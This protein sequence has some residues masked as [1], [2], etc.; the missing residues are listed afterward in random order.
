[1]PKRRSNNTADK[2]TQQKLGRRTLQCSS[3]HMS[4]LRSVDYRRHLRTHM[5][6]TTTSVHPVQNKF[7]SRQSMCGDQQSVFDFKTMNENEHYDKDENSRDFECNNNIDYHDT[8][9]D[10]TSSN[11][12]IQHSDDDLY[13]LEQRNYDTDI[14]TGLTDDDN[15]YKRP[16]FT[17]PS[18]PDSEIPLCLNTMAS[19]DDYPPSVFML[20]IKLQD[21]F[22]RNKVSLKMYDETIELFDNY[23]SSSDFNKYAR[24]MSRNTFLKRVEEIFHT[25]DLRPTYGSV[26]INNG[27]LATVPV[28]DTKAMILSILHDNELM[29][30]ENFAEGLDIFTGTVD[31]NSNHNRLYGE[32]HTGKA[33]TPAVQRFCGSQGKYMPFGMVVFGDKSHTD[34][35]GSLSCTPIT[36]TA[37]FFN[38]KTRNNPASWRPIAYIPNLSHG[39]GG[40]GKSCD[41]VQ[42]EHNCLAYALKSL[43]ALSEEGGLRATVMDREVIVK[44]F[45][46]FFIGDTEGFNKW[47]G[48]YS[49]SQP[50]VSRPYRDCHCGYNELNSLSPTCQYTKVSEFRRAMRLVGHHSKSGMDM[51]KR[52]SRHPIKNALYQSKLPLSNAIH[53]ANKMCPPESLHT[54]D[55][56]LTIYMQESLQ[57][58]MSGGASRD[59]LD[60]Q[61]VKMYYAIARQSERDF[62]RGAVRSGLID[63]T[64]CQSSER[65]GNFFILMCIAHTH[66]GSII[67]KHELNY[68]QSH[69]EK[70]LKFLKLY[71]SME[72]WFHD[73]RDKNE[74]HRAGNAIASVMKSIELYFPRRHDSNGYNIPKM[75]GLAKMRDYIC[76]FGS[77]I[78]FYGG[79]GEASHKTFV[80]AP[81]LKTQRRVKEFTTQT[82]TQYY[83]TMCLNKALKCLD[84][85]G[86]KEESVELCVENIVDDNKHYSVQGKYQVE[87]VREGLWITTSRNKHLATHGLDSTFLNVLERMTS[88]R[89]IF[90]GFTRAVVIDDEGDKY[91]YNAHP[92]YHDAPWY[93]WAYVHYEI[94]D[95]E[96]SNAAYYPS[97]I[98]GFIQE[99]TEINVIIQCAIEP[100]QWSQLEEDFI[101]KLRLNTT[102]GKEEMVPMSSLVHPICVVPNFG[103]ENNDE[104]MM[105]LPKG[106]W[107]DYFARFINQGSNHR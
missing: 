67:L 8:S 82:A 35:H 30:P 12:S 58:L 15:L 36:F 53:G 73:S 27:L 32:I 65:K 38:R 64:R 102:N 69:W 7:Q 98:L 56:G 41:K 71:L 94:E 79:P 2:S 62:P 23:I 59:E 104:Y 96:N 88:E 51:L 91:S 83:N 87:Y 13:Y 50:G 86:K 74:V 22:Q 78:N 103:L 107:S 60:I 48:H 46:H 19:I 45:I 95:S 84:I 47:L 3:C 92:S 72:E 85:H 57:G 14:F 24:L 16:Y 80:K 11:E 81:G 29:Q 17:S 20:Q 28:F 49:G 54:L 25:T 33:W 77:A 34:L 37:T 70:W 90:V 42:D 26:R 75:H 66:E 99:G 89:R 31:N 18:V 105:I 93:D 1:M 39:K 21:L 97:K 55:A 100:L 76:E 52:L 4:F 44:P 43:I 68:R 9:N 10:S 40:K 101:V 61:H 5:V 63:S 106:Q 6:V